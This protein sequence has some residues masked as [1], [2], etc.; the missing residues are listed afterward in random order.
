MPAALAG[1]AAAAAAATATAAT[2]GGR[3]VE[4]SRKEPG[5][6]P[7]KARGEEAAWLREGAGTTREDSA[8]RGRERTREKERWSEVSGVHD[9]T[10]GAPSFRGALEADRMR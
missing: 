1:A 5:E 3:R 10:S 4:R 8:G 7:E 6:E 9:L 2:G